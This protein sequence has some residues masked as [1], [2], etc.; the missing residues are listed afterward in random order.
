MK[1]RKSI[2]RKKLTHRE[3]KLLEGVAAGKTQTKAAQDAGYAHPMQ[4]GSRAMNNIRDKAP[5]LLARHGLDD[6][7]FVEKCLL[8]LTK[9]TETKVFKIGSGEESDPYRILYSKPLVAWG[10][11][12][13]AAEL[14]ANMKG[15]LVKEQETPGQQIRVVIVNA[16]NRPPRREA[17][18]IPSV[19]G[20]T[21]PKK[22]MN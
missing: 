15:L 1:R 14:I 18:E 19:P 7:T 20:L 17:I 13:R 11:R 9:A 2:P 4:S 22:E 3:R 16:A 12:A 5:D 10:P 8:P 6:D 21:A